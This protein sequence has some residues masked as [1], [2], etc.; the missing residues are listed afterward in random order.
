MDIR[1]LEM[2]LAVAE[3]E[4]YTKAGEQLH[5]AHS[6]IHRQIR[7]LE[8]EFKVH[9]LK[10]TGK[11]LRLTEMGNV[12]L[13]HAQRILNEIVILKH[14][15]NELT[16][17]Q[18][19]RLRLGTATATLAS[20]LPSVLAR[21]RRQYPSVQLQGIAGNADSLIEEVQK[22]NMD[23]AIVVLPPSILDEGSFKCNYEPLFKEEFVLAM[24]KSHPLA[25]RTSVPLEQLLKFPFIMYSKG[26][27]IRKLFDRMFEEAGA[28]PI[29]SMELENEIF[30]EKMIEIDL[31]MAFLSKHRVI[32]DKLNY[33]KITGHPIYL[34]IGLVYQK[35]DY[36][37][38]SAREFA[39]ICREDLSVFA[40]VV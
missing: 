9:L 36:I 19:E 11:Q 29:I 32:S 39:R 16:G 26:S 3:N 33:V 18:G 4:G 35:S 34:E 5:V 25:T 6:A 38:R 31:G 24:G 23:L 20:F 10:K 28:T 15:M 2:F 1:Q 17:E 8:H 27:Y 37:P 14:H 40:S 12:L 21:F 22:G 7:M 13:G 30:I